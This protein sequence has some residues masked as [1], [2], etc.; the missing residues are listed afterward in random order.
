MGLE[1]RFEGAIVLAQLS[2]NYDSPLLFQASLKRQG[3][4]A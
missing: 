1:N 3:S 4:M 2:I